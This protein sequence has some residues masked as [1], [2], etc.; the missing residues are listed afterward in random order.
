[1]KPTGTLMTAWVTAIS[2]VLAF[3]SGLVAQGPNPGNTVNWP[4]HNLDLAGSRFS[5][6]DQINPSNVK[7]L[8]PR[9][10]FQYGVIDGVSNQTTPVV[11]DGVMYVTDPRGSV[12][13]IN[14]ADG[15][16]LWTYDVSE[17]IGGGRREGYI[18][19][20]RGV[21]FAGGVV[22]TAAGSFLFALDAKTGKP[23]PGFG[24]N[25][26]A[27]VIL[28]VIHQRFPD[29]K[30]A[31]TLG[32][33]FTTAPQV[34]NGVIY[35]GSTRSESH[36]PGGHVLAVDAK[37]GKVLWHFNTVPQDDKD[38]GWDI[39]GPT[40][41]GGERNG[42]GI[43]ETPS[44]DPE[45][46]LLYVAVGN[47]FGDSTKRA[48][49]NLFTDSI[50]ALSL[51]TGTLKWYF[52]QT[53]HDVWDY[54]S[55]NQPILFDMQVRGQRVKALAEASKNGFLYILNR[56]TGLP[57]HPI[58]EMPVPT[59]TSRAGEQPW[60]TQPIP[61]TA[62]GKPM[63]PVSP[64]APIDILAGHAATRTLVPMFTPPGPNQ[65]HAPGTGGGANYGP[66]SYSPRTGLLYVNAI[67]QPTDSGRPAQ[68]Y[69][70]AFDP[71]TGELVWQQTFEGF[72]QAGSVV[73]ASDLVFVGTGSNVAGYFFA[74]HAKTGELLWKFNTGSGVFSSPSVYMVNGEQFVTVGS[75]GGERGRRGGDL[76]LSFALPRQ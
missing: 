71:T 27:S 38:Q 28:D 18:F 73:T 74:Y 60:P 24:K 32:Y 37:T 52:Q 48:G 7:S 19:R 31:I 40:W 30:S 64:V 50:L 9:F 55:G 54:D 23:I 11:V 10:L 75:G 36:V 34:H 20:N 3:A 59:H 2:T 47:P 41:V 29:V 42:G 8:T 33:W 61:H 5:T 45:L 58:K 44:I 57:V 25:G 16:L 22:Y 65:I 43:W 63:A 62:A 69:F 39:A 13:A 1:M 70:S 21:C 6:L 35:I 72:G 66:I 76:I 67:D 4:L 14:A 51:D 15:H 68:G 12:Y 26:Q 56:E 46:G 49:I 17:L 53:H